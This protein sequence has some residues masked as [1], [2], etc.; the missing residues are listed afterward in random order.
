MSTVFKSRQGLGQDVSI[1]KAGFRI[2]N[3]AGNCRSPPRFGESRSVTQSTIYFG[4][5]VVIFQLLFMGRHPF[6]GRF[7]GAERDFAG[8]VAIRSFDSHS[9]AKSGGE[10]VASS[11]TGNAQPWDAIPRAAFRNYLAG[12]FIPRSDRNRVNG[13]TPLDALAK[14]RCSACSLCNRR[15][16]II[17]RICPNAR[18]CEIENARPGPGCFN[19]LLL[20]AVRSAV[21]FRIFDKW[22]GKK[23]LELD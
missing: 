21:I 9:G 13:L 8:N 12:V 1:V 22:N 4:L 10:T 16:S 20:G 3:A 19:F 17:F 2:S 18:G 14:K 5:A 7:L 6:S 11:H 23:N 15:P